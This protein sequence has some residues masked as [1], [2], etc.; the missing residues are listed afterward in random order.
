M[1]LLGETLL[2]KYNKLFSS[3][4]GER[5]IWVLFSKETGVGGKETWRRENFVHN[6]MEDIPYCCSGFRFRRLMMPGFFISPTYQAD[7]LLPS[8]LGLF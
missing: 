6:L 8:S 2:I 1:K 4:F 7:G 3:L 5:G